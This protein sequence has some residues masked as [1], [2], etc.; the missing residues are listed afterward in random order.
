MQW[1]NFAARGQCGI[2]KHS[3]NRL[4]SFAFPIQGHQLIPVWL[5]DETTTEPAPLLCHACLQRGRI[6]IQLDYSKVFFC[7][8]CHFTDKCTF[9]KLVCKKRNWSLL[10]L[11]C[12]IDFGGKHDPE[13]TSSTA[14]VWMQ[15]GTGRW[16]GV[17]SSWGGNSALNHFVL[18]QQFGILSCHLTTW[19]RESHIEEI[20]DIATKGKIS[21]VLRK[22]W[23]F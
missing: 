3:S 4:I 11:T 16:N 22:R 8:F 6:S 23:I 1:A 19:R 2:F 20:A 18:W 13:I 10:I 17:V 5:C 7:C 15:T 9:C 12:R 21:V 14:G